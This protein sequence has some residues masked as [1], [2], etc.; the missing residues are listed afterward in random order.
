[1]IGVV[2]GM[3]RQGRKIHLEFDERD[4]AG[5]GSVAASIDCIVIVVLNLIFC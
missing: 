4:R 5:L 2:G 1:M 3:I